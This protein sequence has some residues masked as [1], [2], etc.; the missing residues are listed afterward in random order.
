MITR[1]LVKGPAGAEMHPAA[2]HDDVY[3]ADRYF[4]D[5][6]NL[7][8]LAGWLS[9]PGEQP[10]AELED[11]RSLHSTLLEHEHLLA[12]SLN[13]VAFTAAP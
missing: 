10:L 9:R 7:Y 2:A 8:R 13:P 3:V 4:T 5:G 11:C 1:Q 6:W 12:L